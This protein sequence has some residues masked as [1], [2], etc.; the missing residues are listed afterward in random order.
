MLTYSWCKE[1]SDY[2]ADKGKK[3]KGEGSRRGER[4]SKANPALAK[5]K[6]GTGRPKRE[7]GANEIGDRRK[8]KGHHISEGGEEKGHKSQNKKKGKHPN[9]KRPSYKT[10][11]DRDN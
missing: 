1:K 11:E 8:V 4:E 3:K 10:N 6:H 7:K 9:Q 5:R 2:D